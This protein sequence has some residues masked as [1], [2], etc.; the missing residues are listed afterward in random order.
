MQ[1]VSIN[2]ICKK[3]WFS[4]LENFFLDLS[5]PSNVVKNVKK[6]V[7]DEYNELVKKVTATQKLKK[8]K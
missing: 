5:K 4:L 1:Q 6:T 7:Y 3:C 8:L 2:R